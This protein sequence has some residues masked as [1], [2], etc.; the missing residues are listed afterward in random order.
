MGNGLAMCLPCSF[1]KKQNVLVS[2]QQPTP[3]LNHFGWQLNSFIYQWGGLEMHLPKL[4]LG[5]CYT[6]LGQEHPV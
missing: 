1:V 5:A 4:F 2:L 3:G 6:A